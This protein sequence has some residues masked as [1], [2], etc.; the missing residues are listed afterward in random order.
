M[1]IIKGLDRIVLILAIIIAIPGFFYG[2]SATKERYKVV[3]KDYKVWQQ[4][5]DERINQSKAPKDEKKSKN[6]GKPIDIVAEL[7]LVGFPSAPEEYSYPSDI[8]LLMGGIT[9]AFAYFI[10]ALFG[11]KIISRGFK[12]IVLWVHR[13]FKDDRP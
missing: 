11:T 2:W 3:S 9:S 13:G 7:N 4:Q 10:I 1:S 5:R 12:Y 6:S 8:K